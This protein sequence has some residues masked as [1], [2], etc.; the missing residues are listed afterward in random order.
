MKDLP[1]LM[2]EQELFLIQ[3]KDLTA[4]LNGH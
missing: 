4:I 2:E 1:L 3:E